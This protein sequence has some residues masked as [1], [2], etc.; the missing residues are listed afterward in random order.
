M[1]VVNSITSYLNPFSRLGNRRYSFFFP[2]LTVLLLTLIAEYLVQSDLTTYDRLGSLLIAGH[3]IV[4]VYFTFRDGIRAGLTVT[5]LA[6]AYYAYIIFTVRTTGQRL[7]AQINTTVILGLIYGSIAIVIGF[8]KQ[9]VDVLIEREADER[10]RL[11]AILDQLPVG[12]VITN[13]QGEVLQGNKQLAAILGRPV[14]QHIHAAG[15]PAYAV[16]PPEEP[17]VWL[18]QGPA[19]LK[20]T[21]RNR[22]II[23]PRKNGRNLVLSVSSSRIRNSAG[24]PIAIAG[25]IRDITHDKKEDMRKNDFINMASHELKTPLTSL[26]LYTDLLAK[27]LT[28]ADTRHAKHALGNLTYQIEKLR[29]LVANL[30]DVSRIQTGKLQFSHEDFRLD[31][32][33]RETARDLNDISGKRKI[34]YSGKGPVTVSGDRFRMAQVLTNLMTNAQK[35]SPKDTP[36]NVSVTRKNGAATVIVRDSGIGIAREH[37]KKIFDRLYQVTEPTEK[38][39]PGLGLGLYISREIVRRHKGKIWVR[40]EKGKGATFYVTLPVSKS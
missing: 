21:V 30:L 16:S 17:A 1:Q 25:I 24:Q 20:R 12:V 35:Y 14:N 13:L 40:S 26:Q 39:Y 6:I 19:P 3:L 2:F 29:T 18:Q 7:E 34:R 5:F 32:L 23:L 36:V 22:E 38:T 8:L 27:K 10:I 33:V 4:L 15:T 31:R 28:H 11:Q 37:Q 9:T